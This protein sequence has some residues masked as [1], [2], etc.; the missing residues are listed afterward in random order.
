MGRK[1]DAGAWGLRMSNPVCICS[2]D[3]QALGS[4]KPSSYRVLSF[5]YSS[6]SFADRKC[7]QGNR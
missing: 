6:T 4:P 5:Q 3:S 1:T 2:L 7:S